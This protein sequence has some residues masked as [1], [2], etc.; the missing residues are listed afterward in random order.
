MAI[1]GLSRPP[2]RS[3]V[4]SQDDAKAAYE[5]LTADPPQYAVYGREYESESQARTQGQALDRMIAALYNGRRFGVTVWVENGKH[6]GALAPK[7]PVQRAPKA[8]G[9]AKK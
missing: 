6:V 9:G 3:R 2:V 8:K 5:L 7:P 4:W 1:E